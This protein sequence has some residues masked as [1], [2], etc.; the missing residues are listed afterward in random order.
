MASNLK[1]KDETEI[2]EESE[3]VSVKVAA[4]RLDCHK[5]TIYSLIETGELSAFRLTPGGRWKIR[6]SAIENFIQNR[7]AKLE[8]QRQSLG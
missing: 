1:R 7:Q 6:S 4:Q 8:R 2:A 3:I 5:N